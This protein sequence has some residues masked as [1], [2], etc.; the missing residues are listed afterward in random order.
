MIL[1]VKIRSR[2]PALASVAYAKK[3]FLTLDL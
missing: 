1:Y 2:K 3:L